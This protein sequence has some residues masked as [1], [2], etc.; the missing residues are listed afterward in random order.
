MNY[1]I[2]TCAWIEWLIGSHLSS[3]FQKY[4]SSPS[5]II[6][7]TIVQFELYKWTCREQDESKALEVISL[8]KQGEVVPLSTELALRAADVARENKLAMADAIVYA[9]ALY[10]N[11]KLI[12]CDKHFVNLQDVIYIEKK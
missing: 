10:S 5:K 11:A 4:L 12:T 8:T 1:L 6:T 2:D 7:P 9:T 3:A